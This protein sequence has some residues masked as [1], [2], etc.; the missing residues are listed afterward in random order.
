LADHPDADDPEA[1]VFP[2]SYGRLSSKVSSLAEKALKGNE[3]DVAEFC[4]FLNF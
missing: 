3:G 4:E 1:Q 2:L